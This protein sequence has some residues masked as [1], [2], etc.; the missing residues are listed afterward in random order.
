MHVQFVERFARVGKLVG[1]GNQPDVGGFA[2]HALDVGNLALAPGRLWLGVSI[3]AAIDD[4]RDARAEFLAN[5]A[6]PRQ[7]ALVFHRVVKERGDG[8]FFVAA[9]FDDN[10]CNAQKV[11]DI[12][13]SRAFA[14]LARVKERGIAKRFNERFCDER[15]FSSRF[16]VCQENGLTAARFGQ[17]AQNFEIEPDERDH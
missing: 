10:R 13:A 9:V 15:F 2:G 4:V 17:Q 1:G 6:E 8:H 11:A 7:A 14:D 5:L 16:R 3:R 12:R